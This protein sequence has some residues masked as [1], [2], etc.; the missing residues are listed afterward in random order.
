MADLGRVVEDVVDR[1]EILNNTRSMVWRITDM[2]LSNRCF[3]CFFA[4]N[5]SAMFSIHRTTMQSQD[6]RKMTKFRVSSRTPF[7]ISLYTVLIGGVVILQ[8][9]LIG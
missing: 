1:F 7:L 8:N 9:Q 2:D 4:R 6:G 5:K 3:T